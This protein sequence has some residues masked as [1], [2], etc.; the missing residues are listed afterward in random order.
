MTISANVGRQEVISASVDVD[1]IEATLVTGVAQNAIQL[2]PNAYIVGGQVDT[3]LAFDSVTS[4][5]VDVVVG[6][7]TLLA[8]G[9]V[10]VLGASVALTTG[11]GIKTNA[12]TWVTVE[13]NGVGG[14][15][16]EGTARLT[17]QYVVDGRACFSEG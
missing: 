2:P 5:D 4:D 13:W 17:V 10:S 3:V 15:Q 1:L 16:T 8:A 6:T 14:S 7:E 12:P 11:Q 9:D